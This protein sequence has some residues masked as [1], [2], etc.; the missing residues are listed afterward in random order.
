MFAARSEVKMQM[1]QVPKYA[2]IVAIFAGILAVSF[3]Q[4][5]GQV[6]RA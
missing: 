1:T 5:E 2:L 6:V 3:G 4:S